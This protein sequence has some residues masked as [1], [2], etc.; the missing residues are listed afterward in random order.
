MERLQVA[1]EQGGYRAVKSDERTTE[2]LILLLL[3][4]LTF[5]FYFIYLTFALFIYVN[6]N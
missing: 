5:I 3:I 4:N 2:P 1:G 6:V